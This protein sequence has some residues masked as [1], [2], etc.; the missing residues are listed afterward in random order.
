[1]AEAYANGALL[2]YQLATGPV[3]REGAAEKYSKAAA[4]AAALRK[5]CDDCLAQHPECPPTPR[6]AGGGSIWVPQDPDNP[7][8]H[9][10]EEPPPPHGPPGEPTDDHGGHINQSRDDCPERHRGC[11]GLVIDFLKNDP[12]EVW[13]RSHKAKITRIMNTT[14]NPETRRR[15]A[16]LLDQ[17]PVDLA[18]KLKAAGCTVDNEQPDLWPYPQSFQYVDAA[19]QL[20][21]WNPPPAIGVAVRANNR[22]EMA[23]LDEAIQLHRELVETKQPEVAFEIIDAHGGPA[24]GS[25][26]DRCG[27]VGTGYDSG[28]SL[29]RA[30]F[31]DGNYRAANKNVCS[32][33]TVDLSC[34]G[35]LTPR[36]TDE[37]NNFG[38][39]SCQK[40]S[41]INCPVH[42][43]WEADGSMSSATSITSCPAQESYRV[44]HA[45][46]DALDV[47]TH[48]NS[49]GE[50]KYRPE[51]AG[52]IS[53]LKRIER[54]GTAFYSDRG[55][56]KDHPPRHVH[57][58][59]PTTA[60]PASCT[61]AR[62]G[63]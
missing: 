10:P 16:E 49:V 12:A 29:Y 8:L 62:C 6:E 13:E 11:I 38:S 50:A 20:Q 42:A 14:T 46:G 19:G 21:T 47:T 7:I 18:A 53:V 52:L 2:E 60:T 9:G 51:F 63:Q 61:G 1:M 26:R 3:S 15:M 24:H 55:Y 44:E 54:A 45:L 43:G 59:Y 28:V 57:V 4:E 17:L 37:L 40:P 32:W 33:F 56:A 23:K 41:I 25:R 39:S 36:V 27:D 58:G 30:D 34:Y 48:D 31:H 35:G 22:Q 5:K